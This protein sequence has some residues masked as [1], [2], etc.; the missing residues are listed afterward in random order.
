MSVGALIETSL[1]PV[2]TNPTEPA[3]GPQRTLVHDLPG[4]EHSVAA[5]VNIAPLQGVQQDPPP[6]TGG[7]ARCHSGCP[8]WIHAAIVACARLQGGRHLALARPK[9]GALRVALLRPG[10]T[11]PHAFGPRR[12]QVTSAA[13]AFASS[14]FSSSGRSRAM[15]SPRTSGAGASV[16][17]GALVAAGG[18][19]SDARKAVAA[20][21]AEA[22]AL[23]EQR[24]KMP[25]TK[26][27]GQEDRLADLFEQLRRDPLSIGRLALHR[28]QRGGQ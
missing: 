18:G 20:E 17:G 19:A 27:L 9:P 24:R 25:V 5:I 15:A 8:L 7:A 21:V 23:S 26:P 4:V 16:A 6:V 22:A 14:A 28:L 13:V 1:E 12:P 10:E 11:R 3:T 2:F